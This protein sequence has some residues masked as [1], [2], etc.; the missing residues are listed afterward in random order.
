MIKIDVFVQDKNWKKY[1]PYPNIYLKNKIKLIKTLPKFI[2]GKKIN[3][4]ILLAGNKEIALLNKKFRNKNKA[5]D[6]LSFPFYKIKEIKKLKKRNLYLGDV[7]LNFNKINKKIF[8]KDFDRLWVHGFLHLL[9]H[10]HY[11]IK[12]FKKMNKIEKLILK[13]FRKSND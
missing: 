13:K 10:K 11:R 3:F 2:K 5:T 9:G 7:I 12:D 4:S 8:K 1:I 6:I